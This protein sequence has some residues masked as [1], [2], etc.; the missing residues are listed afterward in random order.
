M[1]TIKYLPVESVDKSGEST[2]FVI[3]PNMASGDVGQPFDMANAA[4]RTVQFVGEFDGGTVVMEGSVMGSTYFTL[5]DATGSPI[6]K[7][8]EDGESITQATRYVRPSMSGGG[9]NMAVDVHLQA[10]FVN[11]RR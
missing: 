8:D 10:R 3:W 9:V 11:V 7:T 2:F 6:S 4:D 1:A 5:D